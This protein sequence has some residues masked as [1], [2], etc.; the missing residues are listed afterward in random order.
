MKRIIEKT[1]EQYLYAKICVIGGLCIKLLPDYMTGIP[2]RLCLFPG[3]KMVFVETKAPGKKPRPIQKVM[4]KKLRDLGF[5]VI[6][7]D[8]IQ[9]VDNL[10]LAFYDTNTK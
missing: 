5:T 7:I 2:D 9:E 3:G 6:V 10:I 1:I 8:G 4:H